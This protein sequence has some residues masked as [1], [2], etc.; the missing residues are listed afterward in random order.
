MMSM[1]T[2]YGQRPGRRQ[3]LILASGSPRRISLLALLSADFTVVP[4]EEDEGE[5]L[6]PQDLV[7]A[8]R[9][10]ASGAQERSSDTIVI[11]AD[12]GVFRDGRWYG[13]PRDHDE[14]RATLRTLSGGWHSVFT[15]LVV[16][17][18]G[19]ERADLVE[20]RVRFKTLAEEEISWYLTQ[21]DV[22]DKAG[23]YAIQG[24]GALFVDRIEGDFYNVVGLPLSTLY[25]RLRELGWNP[26]EG[27]P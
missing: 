26:G 23:A 9:T 18:R 7:R 13:K 20:T 11:G 27:G 24:R 22:V 12:T 17:A 14:A 4:P 19:A 10:K 15:G 3:R 2:D 5:I 21:E 25:R 1:G 6:S 16:L 8:A